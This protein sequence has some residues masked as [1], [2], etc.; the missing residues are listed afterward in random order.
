[1]FDSPPPHQCFSLYLLG[2]STI[3]GGWDHIGDHD[4]SGQFQTL[5]PSMGIGFMIPIMVPVVVP[6]L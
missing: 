2:F 5:S 3:L 6:W 1:M 4:I